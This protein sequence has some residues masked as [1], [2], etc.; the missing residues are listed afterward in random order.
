MRTYV[1]TQGRAWPLR[2]TVATLRRCRE[3]CDLANPETWLDEVFR[4]PTR[5]CE[6]VHAIANNGFSLEELENNVAGEEIAKLRQLLFEEM[7]DFFQDRTGRGE[8]LAALVATMQK[9]IS[10]RLAAEVNAITKQFTGF[11][12]SAELTETN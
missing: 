2:V 11:A 6:I 7:I 8:L 10:E 12:A 4:S 5:L 9:T 1:D 3:V